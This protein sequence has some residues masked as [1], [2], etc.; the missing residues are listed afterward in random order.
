[1]STH[2]HQTADTAVSAAAKLSPP[3]AVLGAHVMGMSVADWIQWLTLLYLLLL[4]S[5]KMWQMWGD[6]KEKWF[7]PKPCE[8]CTEN[9]KGLK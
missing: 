9:Q 4:V 2:H 6:I 7:K 3:T 1:M 8:V 5:H